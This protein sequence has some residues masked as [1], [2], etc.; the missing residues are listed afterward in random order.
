MIMNTPI[1]DFVKKYNGSSPLRMH[2]PGHKGADFLGFE[3]LDITEFDGADDLYHP[4]GIIAQSEK[5]ASHLFGCPTYYCT[6]GSSQCIRAMMYLLNIYAKKQGRKPLIAAGRNV[7]KT[8]VSAAA[9]LDFDIMW[10]YPKEEKSYLSCNI[11]PCELD[12]ILRTSK[13][14]PI[15]VYITS[16]DYLGKIADIKGLAEVCRKHNVLLAVDNAHGAYLKFLEES[17]HPIDLGADL[18]CDSAHKTLPVITGGAY[19]HFSK[20]ITDFSCKDIKNALALFGSTSPSYLILQSLDACNLYLESYKNKLQ[21]FLP[22]ITE[23]KTRLGKKGFEFYGDEPM[24][25]TFSAKKYGYTGTE[26]AEILKRNNIFCEF[27]DPDYLVLM[28]TPET[29]KSGLEKLETILSSIPKKEPKTTVQPQLIKAEKVM[30]VREAA[31]S[32]SEILSIENCE[33]K[34]LSSVTVGCP[35]AVPILVCGEIITE[36]VIDCFKYYGITH[37]CVVCGKATSI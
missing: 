8:F 1:S 17:R 5:N 22:L 16:P 15:A 2:M 29:E 18:C 4:A 24:K 10:L 26:L 6:E 30:T 28:P 3:H 21:N 14:K 11:T 36:E 31:L 27:C 32:P 25:L 7:H 20:N 34:I 35:P 19:L 33:G 9:L 23:M 12:E 37:C 13:V